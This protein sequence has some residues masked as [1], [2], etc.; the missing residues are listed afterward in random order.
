VPSSHGFLVQILIPLYDNDGV[1]VPQNLFARVQGELTDRF[2]GLTAHVRSPARGPWTTDE[3]DVRRD[4]VVILEVVT[5]R[6]D[7]PWWDQYRRTL[8]SQFRQQEILIR[9]L[10]LERL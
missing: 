4:D 6:L 5:D 10:P 1:R 3:W 8:E 9:A 7:R 2:G